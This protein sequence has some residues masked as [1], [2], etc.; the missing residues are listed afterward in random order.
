MGSTA[1]PRAG[2]HAR[3]RSVRAALGLA[4][5][6]GGLLTGCT[7]GADPTVEPAAATAAAPGSSWFVSA[8]GDSAVPENRAGTVS[9]FGDSFSV[10]Q[11]P[12]PDL[13][14]LNVPYTP[15]GVSPT[16]GPEPDSCGGSTKPR[17]V[18]PG[19]TA[20][21]GSATVTWQASDQAEVQGYR[22]SAVS[23]QLVGGT[24]PAPVQQTVGQVDDC[25][26]LSVTLGGLTPGVPYV[27]WLEEQTASNVRTTLRWV[28][29]GTS[30][31]V[32]IG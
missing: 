22:V 19:V 15:Q 18:A 4:L 3:R 27:F 6:A 1:G 32:V 10:P 16:L 8:G 29:V 9:G 21:A 11:P 14:N 20:G 30:D 23:Q 26:Q 5:G 31:A 25:R 13:R 7:A 28:Q 24:Q 12:R 2:Q 17:R